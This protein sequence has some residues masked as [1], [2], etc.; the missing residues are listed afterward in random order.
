MR[1]IVLA[2]IACYLWLSSVLTTGRPP[3][4]AW[5]SNTP[6]ALVLGIIPTV[7]PSPTMTPMAEETPAPKIVKE[8]N[9]LSGCGSA[10]AVRH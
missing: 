6:T 7:T 8:S 2:V 5:P 1:W 3:V 4:E 10:R 9:R